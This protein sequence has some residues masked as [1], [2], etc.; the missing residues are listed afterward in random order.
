MVQELSIEIENVDELSDL[1]ASDEVILVDSQKGNGN[2]YDIIGDEIASIDHH[3]TFKKVD[4]AFMD[5]RPEVGACS[6]IIADYYYENNIPLTTEIAT[7][8]M[9]GIK[10]DTADM[11]RGVSKL[12]LEVFHKL[13]FEADMSMISYF[14]SNELQ[15]K[16]LKAYEAAIDS[17]EVNSKVS[18]AHTGENC[19]DGLIATISDFIMALENVDFS[20]VYSYNNGGVKFSVRSSEYS[21]LNAGKITMQALEGYGTGGGHVSMAGGFAPYNSDVDVD[22]MIE[23]IKNNFLRYAKEIEE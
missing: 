11:T 6:S 22:I 8:L 19:P 5:I 16:D 17:I 23:N 14:S 13:Y 7:A 20:V 3:P 10:I 15:M 21:G 9:Y 18:F 2:T 12:D 4:Y 1:C